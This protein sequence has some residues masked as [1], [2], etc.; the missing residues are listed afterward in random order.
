MPKAVM[1]SL[2]LRHVRVPDRFRELL[3]S[4]TVVARFRLKRLADDRFDALTD[5][6]ARTLQLL[7]RDLPITRIGV[8][9][10][11]LERVLRRLECPSEGTV[12]ISRGNRES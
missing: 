7:F 4:H 1:N 12:S 5:Q 3:D 6:A 10:S 2:G 11:V 9:F 8:T